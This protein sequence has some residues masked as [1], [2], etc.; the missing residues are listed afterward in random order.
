MSGQSLRLYW[1][2]KLVSVGKP[3][4]A[5]L[6]IT[7]A[8]WRLIETEFR[9]QM[10]WISFMSVQNLFVAFCEPCFCYKRRRRGGALLRGLTRVIWPPCFSCESVWCVWQRVRNRLLLALIS[11]VPLNHVAQLTPFT[12]PIKSSY[13]K[14]RTCL[15]PPGKTWP[16]VSGFRLFQLKRGLSWVLFVSL[17]TSSFCFSVLSPHVEG[18]IY[19]KTKLE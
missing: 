14:F 15:H 17:K 5:D 3:F 9:L 2:T 10:S 12:R 19:W 18:K 13:G 11:A 7:I 4:S 1:K 8:A 6:C 16:V